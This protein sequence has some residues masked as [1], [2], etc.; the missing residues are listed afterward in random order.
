MKQIIFLILILFVSGCTVTKD[1]K[2]VSRVIASPVL[3][4]RVVQYDAGGHPY[5]PPSVVYV[6]GKD[7]IIEVPVPVDVVRDSL[8]KVACPTLNLDSLKKALTRTIT[9][10]RVD[11]FFKA[12]PKLSEL[13]NQQQYNLSMIQGQYSQLQ[14]QTDSYKKESQH[15]LWYIIGISILA[16]IIIIF[17]AY[18]LLKP[19]AKL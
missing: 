11:T 13:F 12:D 19:K 17:E 4:K 16:F 7:S 10:E 14:K 3:T 9:K 15:R 2:A 18:L 1:N 6:K 5:V 8:I